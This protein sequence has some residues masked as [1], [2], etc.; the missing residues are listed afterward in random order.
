M[1][2]DYD[3]SSL[4]LALSG[5]SV[6]AESQLS[7]QRAGRGGGS[8]LKKV[9]CEVTAPLVRHART[10]AT[11]VVRA[12]AAPDYDPTSDLDSMAQLCFALRSTCGTL[13][14]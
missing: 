2:H 9:V 12:A 14:R 13:G 7:A 4:A 11:A 6:P 1:A 3:P 5:F 10:V 8:K